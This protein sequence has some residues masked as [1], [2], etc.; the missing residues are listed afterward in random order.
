MTT[1]AITSWQDYNP[2][3]IDEA[4][5]ADLCDRLLG[6]FATQDYRPRSYQGVVDARLRRCDYVAITDASLAAEVH[7]LTE[8]ISSLYGVPV[9]I[10]AGQDPLVYRYEQGIGFVTHHDEVTEVEVAR[11]ENNGQP[12]VHGNITVTVSLSPA[13]RYE[14]GELYFV[15]PPA[16]FKLPVGAAVTFPATRRVLHGVRPIASGYRFALLLRFAVA[17]AAR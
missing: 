16:E 3:V 7:A 13:D 11:A 9:E 6:Y 8:P 2:R 17:D 15:D 12:V 5:T 4:V 10:V 1:T 14:G